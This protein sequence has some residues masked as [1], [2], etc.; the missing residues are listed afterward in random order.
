VPFECRWAAQL[1]ATCSLC[2]SICGVAIRDFVTTEIAPI[3]MVQGW[4][5]VVGWH[6]FKVQRHLTP[7]TFEVTPAAHCES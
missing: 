2:L 3:F 6:C 7:P 5:F 4:V 1:V